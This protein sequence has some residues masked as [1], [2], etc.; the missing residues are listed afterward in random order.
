[1][2]A[3]AIL[4][5]TISRAVWLWREGRNKTTGNVHSSGSTPSRHNFTTYTRSSL[6]LSLSL[7]I[8]NPSSRLGSFFPSA[9]PAPVTLAVL[10]FGCRF[11]VQQPRLRFTSSHHTHRHDIYCQIRASCE[12]TVESII[13]GKFF[14]SFF[15]LSFPLPKK[16]YFQRNKNLRQQMMMGSCVSV[17][18][19]Q[20]S[21]KR[22][23]SCEREI[24][25]SRWCFS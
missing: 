11:F 22:S 6:S 24:V 7:A 8:Y 17:F 20:T 3:C 15:P 23:V 25:R 21:G 2:F 18:V 5:S 19:L 4:N 12:Q 16:F 1:M 10:A 13:E 14:L 9:M